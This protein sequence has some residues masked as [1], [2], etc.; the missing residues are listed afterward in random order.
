MAKKPLMN[1]RPA[2]LKALGIGLELSMV[3]GGLGYAGYWLDEKFGSDPWLLLTGVFLGISGGSWHAI[4][5]ANGGKLPDMGFDKLAKKKDK[6][7]DR[8]D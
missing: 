6:P 7:P 5:M 8:K 1:L 4:K 3:I 2:D